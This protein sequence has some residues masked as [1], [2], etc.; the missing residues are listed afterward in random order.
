MPWLYPVYW[1]T[2]AFSWGDESEC[3]H[4]CDCCFVSVIKWWTHVSSVVTN[5]S[6]KSTGS[7]SNQCKFSRE[8]LNGMRVWAS[9]R[10]LGMVL[11]DT[12]LIGSSSVNMLRTLGCGMPRVL[13]MCL[14]SHLSAITRS[15][16]LSGNFFLIRSSFRSSRMGVALNTVFL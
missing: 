14:I 11:S 1:M 9:V 4:C 3:F 10:S 12:F 5:L 16:T 15:W 8:T 2:L 7:P 13:T 6:R